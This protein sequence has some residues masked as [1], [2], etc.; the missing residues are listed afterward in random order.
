MPKR[1]IGAHRGQCRASVQ[2]G[3]VAA[4]AEAEPRQ[5]LGVKVGFIGGGNMAT[6]MIG[7]FI[8]AGTCLPEDVVVCVRDVSSP[9]SKAL[10]WV[11]LPPANHIPC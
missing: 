9:K 5:P 6:A 8:A 4:R 2:R 7:G 10:R 11:S 3:W 1:G